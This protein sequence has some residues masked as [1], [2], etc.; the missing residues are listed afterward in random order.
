MLITFLIV[1]L[2]ASESD[3]VFPDWRQQPTS[4]VSVP[5]LPLGGRASASHDPGWIVVS[6][7]PALFR[8][9][10]ETVEV[11]L[12]PL[13]T[14]L[15]WPVDHAVRPAMGLAV[16]PLRAMIRYGEET[17][18]IERGQSFVHPTGRESF[19]LYPTAVLDGSMSSRWGL[20]FVDRDFFGPAWRLQLGGA[21]TVAADGSVRALTTTPSL[22][23]FSQ[24]L[25]WGGSYSFSRESSFRIPD[26]R[27]V[28]DPTMDGA[29]SERRVLTEVGLSTPGPISGAGWDLNYQVA[30]RD[31][32]VPVRIDA[33]IT[34]ADVGWFANGDR[35]ILGQELDHTFTLGAGWSNQENPGAPTKGQRINSRMWYTLAQGGGDLVGFDVQGAKY[36]LLG[37]ERYVYKKG[38]LDPY[39]DLDPVQIIKMLDPS[40]LRQR[41][42]QRKILAI[43]FQ[44]S[45]IWELDEQHHPASFFLFPSLGGD[46]PA[47]S[48]PGRYL[49]GKSLVGGTVEYRWP[50]WKYVDGTSFV[51]CAWAAP[52]FWQPTSER[53][54]PGIG[55]GFRVRLPRMFLF[56]I[57]AAK[58]L[59]GTALIATTDA[60]F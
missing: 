52:H 8:D 20:T 59:A 38:D 41:L 2:A 22:G 33:R 5:K 35:G 55:G 6:E 56:R 58:G 12:H 60:E 11:T 48:Y 30:Y 29:V 43:Y 44:A 24:Q 13:L 37:S 17:N 53:V 4:P 3:S 18:L 54:A 19:F 42:T 16:K 50:I 26:F 21:L 23:P 10:L 49:M 1:C 40:T 15:I 51:E 57:Q 39:L 25:R 9:S 28:W 14:A 45:R 36:F 31:I 27:P 47:R 34:K 32:G 7:H 46:A